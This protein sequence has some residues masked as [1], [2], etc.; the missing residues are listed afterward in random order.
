MTPLK[1][2]K[3]LD[4]IEDIDAVNR[5]NL[6][7]A[8]NN[9][10]KSKELLN[11]VFVSD[12]ANIEAEMKKYTQSDFAWPHLAL[13]KLFGVQYTNKNKKALEYPS[14]S[15]VLAKLNAHNINPAINGT[16]I[17]AIRQIERVGALLKDSI[18]R[19]NK[20]VVDNVVSE[21]TLNKVLTTM[22]GGGE[23]FNYPNYQSFANMIKHNNFML[24]N[25][26]TNSINVSGY[27]AEMHGGGNAMSIE[28]ADGS[29]FDLDT[30]DEFVYS[31]DAINKTDALD[32]GH[33]RNTIVQIIYK[34]I[35]A[36]KNKNKTLSNNSKS[37]VNAVIKKL[38]ESYKHVN[39]TLHA[40]NTY[41]TYKGGADNIE[42]AVVDSPAY[43][44]PIDMNNRYFRQLE[45]AIRE[46]NKRE[47]KVL[48][49][50]EG[51]ASALA[52]AMG[53]KKNVS[54]NDLSI[55]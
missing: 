51:L 3:Q 36:L 31:D 22:S 45:N 14:V 54:N 8:V 6:W 30:S 25:Y 44:A 53:L 24:L 37:K 33:M 49:I 13:C 35:A 18:D 41:N 26:A 7:S 21:L 50:S 47:L 20:M 2:A 1:I 48:A 12:P 16:E 5:T 34:Q 55:Q 46:K 52:D 9:E 23:E 28:M 42:M 43:Y 15:Q 17:S 39:D 38:A 29:K 40:L 4:E 19:L 32:F 10:N 11:T 27:T